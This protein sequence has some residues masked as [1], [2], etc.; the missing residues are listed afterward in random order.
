MIGDR[1]IDK[2]QL[3]IAG[4]IRV[5]VQLNVIPI[6]EVYD[7]GPARSGIA[8]NRIGNCDPGNTMS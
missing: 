1:L 4:L 8:W 2:S 7:H 3:Q 6:F 5:K